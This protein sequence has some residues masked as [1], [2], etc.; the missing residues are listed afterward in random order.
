M[1]CGIVEK[2]EVDIAGIVQFAC[3]QLAHAENDEA[4]I[5]LRR[6]GMRQRQRARSMGGQHQVRY[7]QAQ[8]RI[9]Q[10][11]QRRRHAREAP[12]AADIGECRNQG[13][14]PLRPAHGRRD[15]RPWCTGLHPVQC[16]HRLRQCR[17]RSLPRHLHHNAMLADQQVREERAAAPNPRQHR[18]PPGG[19]R[20]LGRVGSAGHEPLCRP[21]PGADVRR[22]GPPRNRPLT[23]ACHGRPWPGRSRAVKPWPLLE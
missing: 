7:R 11:G 5:A 22:S 12:F 9:R 18:R 20:Q 13:D 17:I 10:G 21:L 8:C 1:R 4:A 2:D 19:R 3:A 14:L 15:L 16:V 23:H 6:P